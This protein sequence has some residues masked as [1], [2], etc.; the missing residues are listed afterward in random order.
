VFI[1]AAVPLLS[2]QSS[3]APS[4]PEVSAQS[5]YEYLKVLA[6]QIGERTAGSEAEGRAAEYIAGQFR[7]WGLKTSVEKFPVPTWRE[8]R[9]RLWTDGGPVVDFPAKTVVFGGV[10][11]PEGIITTSWTLEPAVCAT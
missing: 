11:K 2:A 3:K 7:S 1:T 6:G 10:T 9:A 4:I 8:Q 5:A